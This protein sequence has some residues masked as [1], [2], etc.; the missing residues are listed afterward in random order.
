MRHNFPTL[1]TDVRPAD[2]VVA[3][4]RD[5]AVNTV[6]CLVPPVFAA[7]ARVFHPALRTTEGGDEEVSWTTVAHANGRIAHPAMQWPS[8]TGSWGFLHGDGQPG[9][10][11]IPPEEGSLPVRQA[12]RL[13]R[14]L[15]AHT[16][17]PERCWFAVWE[18]FGDLVLP[19]GDEIPRVEMPARPML[20]LSGP[21][22]AATTSF[23]SFRDQLA[24]L[25]WPDDRAWCVATD[26]DLMTTYVG[27]SRECVAALT[28]DD[29]LEA[30]EISADQ[31]LAWD[32]DPVNP[33]PPDRP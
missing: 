18:G 2:W 8:I 15:A 4:V 13:A 10:W 7:Y 3:A 29:G 25:W 6:S 27:G 20:L 22:R 23:A 14:L 30:M 17:T 31:R 1:R 21:L 9:L 16:T 26:V 11:D 12:A 24:S 33:V 28:A 5:F 19:V 32:S